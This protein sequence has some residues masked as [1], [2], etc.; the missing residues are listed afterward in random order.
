MQPRVPGQRRHALVQAGIVLHRAGAERVE[1]GIEVEVALGDP[2][3]VTDDLGLGDLGQAWRCRPAQ[4]LGQQLA[5][6]HLRH[7]QRGWHE[8]AAAGRSLLEDR[9]GRLALQRGGPRRGRAPRGLVGAMRQPVRLDARIGV[10]VVFVDRA[11]AAGAL[12][13]IDAVSGL[14]FGVIATSVLLALIVIIGLAAGGFGIA[15]SPSSHSRT[16]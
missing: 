5:H 9:A 8:R 11:H 10:Q 1:A 12:C 13:Y 15:G 6:V 2:D 4:A 14:L 16:T 7:V 3:V